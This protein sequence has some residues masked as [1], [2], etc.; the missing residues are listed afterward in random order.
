M[1][2]IFDRNL[3]VV[4]NQDVGLLALGLQQCLY[5]EMF[6]N[7][8]FDIAEPEMSFTENHFSPA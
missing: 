2:K 3:F 6:E 7:P 8:F 5:G 4:Y 1:L